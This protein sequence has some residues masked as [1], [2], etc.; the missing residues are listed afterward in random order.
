M[1]S[2]AIVVDQL[3][4]GL[5]RNDDVVGFLRVGPGVGRIGVA[6]AA[7]FLVLLLAV[8][9]QTLGLGRPQMVRDRRGL[10][11]VF[12]AHHARQILVSRMRLPN[13][14]AGL[15]GPSRAQHGRASR[16]TQ[17]RQCNP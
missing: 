7:L 1:A 9:L 6:V 12:V 15:L 11:H 3:E 17:G 2:R 14:L 16:D 8:T 4:V 5:V 13:L 10:G